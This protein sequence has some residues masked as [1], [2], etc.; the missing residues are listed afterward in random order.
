MSEMEIALARAYLSAAG[1]DAVG[2]LIRSVRDL[3]K[4]RAL[5]SV[6]FVRGDL[7]GPYGCEETSPLVADP[8][9]QE[10]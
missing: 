10:R 5:V 6:G 2:A 9:G 4:A 8:D 7:P 1:Q 3:A